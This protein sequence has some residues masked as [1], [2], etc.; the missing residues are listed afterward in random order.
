MENTDGNRT[1]GEL[2]SEFAA[3]TKR[4]VSYEEIPYPTSA[5]YGVKH[6]KKTLYIPNGKDRKSYV[7]AFHDHK[8]MDDGMELYFGAFIP[9]FLPNNQKLLIRERN[10]VDRLNPFL[11]KHTLTTGHRHFDS[12]TVITGN[13]EP[14][15][16]RLFG[17]S[18]TQNEVMESL[19]LMEGMY[20]GI[21]EVNLDFAPAFWGKSNLGIFTTQTWIVETDLI[22][23][24][25]AKAEKLYELVA[26]KHGLSSNI[27]SVY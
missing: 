3:Q 1:A 23:A 14:L 25:Y 2:L 21:N 8:C 6:H 10:I 24:L 20:V 19:K 11:K 7:V 22:E 12:H 26:K 4:E 27:A 9:L 13:D 17:D 16:R 5:I 18:E 15:L